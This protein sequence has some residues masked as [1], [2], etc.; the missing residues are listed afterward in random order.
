MQVKNLVLTFVLSTVYSITLTPHKHSQVAIC[1]FL[2]AKINK[3]F[4]SHPSSPY[5]PLLSQKLASY[6][7]CSG[8]CIYHLT[9]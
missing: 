2:Y 6:A 1:I 9:I 8:S 4:S 5:L 3:I 7:Y